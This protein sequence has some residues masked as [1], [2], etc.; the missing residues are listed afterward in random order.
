MHSVF[1]GEIG[2]V[3]KTADR[4]NFNIAYFMGRSI[5]FHDIHSFSKN[6][7]IISIQRTL[8]RN[9]QPFD[10]QGSDDKLVGTSGLF[11]FYS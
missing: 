10:N 9:L 4:S 3:V 6:V 1:V 8:S 11:L 7:Q 5:L 2:N